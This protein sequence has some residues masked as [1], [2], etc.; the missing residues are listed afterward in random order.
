M[1]KLGYNKQVDWIQ[2]KIPSNVGAPDKL[3]RISESLLGRYN[4]KILDIK[5]LKSIDSL[6]EKFF[7]TFNESFKNIVNFIPLTPNEIKAIGK[8]YFPMLK[9]EL[10]IILQDEKDNIA[11][12][13]I[14]FPNLSESFQKAKG[15]LFPF[16]WYHIMRGFRNYKSID[17]MMLGAAPDWQNKGISSIYHSVLAVRLKKLDI[18]YAISNP[19]AEDN[20]AYKVWERYE[21]FPYMK[22]RCY[23]KTI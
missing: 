18:K 11:G 19:Q 12:F 3:N 15:K 17:L 13:G 20:S 4:L 10:T 16:G 2:V 5:K 14:C 22:R 23:I 1:E 21:H 6:V 7:K 9:P 8:S